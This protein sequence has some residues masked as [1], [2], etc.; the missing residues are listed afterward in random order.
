MYASWISCSK[1]ACLIL[2]RWNWL[3]AMH[4]LWCLVLLCMHRH[5]PGLLSRAWSQ[6][7]LLQN[8]SWQLNLCNLIHQ[9]LMFLWSFSLLHQQ[10]FAV[11]S[12]PEKA[13]EHS[14]A[15]H[16]HA[17]WCTITLSGPWAQWWCDRFFFASTVSWIVIA[18]SLWD[19]PLIYR[20][21]LS[22]NKTIFLSPLT[23][24]SIR[25]ALVEGE[26]HKRENAY[27]QIHRCVN[28]AVTI[29]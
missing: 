25:N 15:N 10:Y 1:V 13:E 4:D 26:A 28:G 12:T 24:Q 14:Q 17:E 11:P 5:C 22:T 20:A 16:P 9:L 7:P 23:Y 21:L 6:L 27:R 3:G 19:H 29:Q 8:F 2:E 18:M